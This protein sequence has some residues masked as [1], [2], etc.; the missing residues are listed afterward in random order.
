MDTIS[1]RAKP[2]LR[3]ASDFKFGCV[4][5]SGRYGKVF[6]CED[7][8]TK[9]LY[10]VKMME[11]SRLMKEHMFEQIE[12]ELFVQSTMI[13]PNLLKVYEWFHDDTYVYVVTEYS[14]KGDMYESIIKKNHTPSPKTIVSYL[15]Q[16]FSVLIF[17]KENKIVHRDIK[18]E[19]IIMFDDDVIKLGDFGWCD[20]VPNDVVAPKIVGTT[21]YL[22]P[23]VVNRYQHDYPIDMWA[24]GVLLFEL[25]TGDPPFDRDTHNETI[26]AIK[27]CSYVFTPNKQSPFQMKCADFFSKVFV[28]N[29]Q[30][31]MTP[32]AGLVFLE[33][34]VDSITE[35]DVEK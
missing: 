5:G 34:M 3:T 27:R 18:P 19:N 16:M 33:S 13:H 15:R 21:V 30:H 2:S 4:L 28:T 24:I 22:S 14:Q 1:F 32:E 23:E 7:T 6:K 9:H 20:V 29:P 11:K 26:D 35:H 8:T 17:L 31:R 10:A 12:R 25:L